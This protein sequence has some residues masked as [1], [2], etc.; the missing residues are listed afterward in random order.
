MTQRIDSG[1]WR[2]FGEIVVELGYATHKQIEAAL[3]RHTQEGLSGDQ[4][5]LIGVTL[6]DMGVM[7]PDQVMA[8]LD[9]QDAERVLR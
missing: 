4:G 1:E 3:L 5:M 6:V 9:A 7:K 8:V 2:R